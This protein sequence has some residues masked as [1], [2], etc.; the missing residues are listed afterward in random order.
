MKRSLLST[1][2]MIQLLACGDEGSRMQR[3]YDAMKA[4][5]FDGAFE[6]FQRASGRRPDDPEIKAAMGILLSLR[7]ISVPAAIQLLEES[8]RAT[9]DARTREQLLKLYLDLGRSRDARQILS[10]QR[11]PVEEFFTPEMSLQR[12]GV[13]CIAEP[14]ERSLK[15]LEKTRET[16]AGSYFLVRCYLTQ[17]WSKKESEEKVKA[18]VVIVSEMKNAEQRCELIAAWPVALR[19]QLTGFDDLLRECRRQFPGSIPVQR[20][21]ALGPGG[22]PVDPGLDH[23]APGQGLRKIFAEAYD[24]PPYPDIPAWK[25]VTGGIN[26]ET[27]SEF[28]QM[29]HEEWDPESKEPPPEEGEEEFKDTRDYDQYFRDARPEG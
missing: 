18:A 14:G 21:L 29:E 9:G 5:N 13:D 7:T 8:L 3:G 20:E 6:E 27:G 24:L 26:L 28:V 16:P 23:I 1:L 25:S 19:G 15:V 10:A 2:V 12:A 22:Y 17:G 11:V 4:G